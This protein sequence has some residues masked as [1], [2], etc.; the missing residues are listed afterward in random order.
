MGSLLRSL[1]ATCCWLYIN[2][3]HYHNT[4]SSYTT[5]DVFTTLLRLLFS[6]KTNYLT[7]HY[8]PL[9][10]R[11]VSGVRQNPNMSAKKMINA[12]HRFQFISTSGPLFLLLLTLFPRILRIQLDALTRREIVRIR[13]M[14]G[15][16]EYGYPVWY[17]TMVKLANRLR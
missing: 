14:G 3:E 10:T 15:G 12:I 7:C 1:R 2:R 9:W 6:C 16:H 4:A 13:E 5:N 17:L 11:S 8:L